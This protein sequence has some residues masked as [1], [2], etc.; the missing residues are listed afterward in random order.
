MI[1]EFRF[2]YRHY[3]QYRRRWFS[4]L[5][6]RRPRRCSVSCC[7]LD[8]QNN[9][10]DSCNFVTRNR[11]NSK[12]GRLFKYISVTFLL[13]VSRQQA[14]TLTCKII[15]LKILRVSSTEK[16]IIKEIVRRENQKCVKMNCMQMWYS[17]INNVSLWIFFYIS[18]IDTNEFW[19]YLSQITRFF[20][21]RLDAVCR[22][23]TKVTVKNVKN[24]NK[25]I[26]NT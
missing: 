5:V 17:F 8:L 25:F 10:H 13:S 6:I 2:Y 22:L 4:H 26:F 14:T 23:L 18:I 20:N 7:D 3:L 24:K 11:M 16:I 1:R 12:R 9:R 21:R 15:V 19:Q